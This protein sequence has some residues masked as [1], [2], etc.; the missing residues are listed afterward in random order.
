[1]LE[2]FVESP[3]FVKAVVRYFDLVGYQNKVLL[4]CAVLSV[5]KDQSLSFAVLCRCGG[6]AVVDCNSFR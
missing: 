6:V 1:M 4:L 2:D 5:C 3:V